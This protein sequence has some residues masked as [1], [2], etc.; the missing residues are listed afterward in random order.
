MGK[1]MY[2]FQGQLWLPVVYKAI[3]SEHQ[4]IFM[5]IFTTNWENFRV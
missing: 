5:L 2:L 3:D 4:A 1:K